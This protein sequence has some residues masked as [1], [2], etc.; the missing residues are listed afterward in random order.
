MAITNAIKM[1][2]IAA[3]SHSMNIGLYIFGFSLSFIRRPKVIVKRKRG[4][5]I[6]GKFLTLFFMPIN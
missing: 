2:N 4:N 6:A 1:P 5:Q 3:I